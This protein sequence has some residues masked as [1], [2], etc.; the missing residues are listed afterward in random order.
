VFI[1]CPGTIER[2]AHGIWL[3]LCVCGVVGTGSGAE[4]DLAW[5]ANSEP[6]LA[7]YRIHYGTESGSLLETIDVGNVTSAK[8]TGLIPGTTY[9]STVTAYNSVDLESSHSSEISFT[10]ALPPTMIDSDNDGLSD[11]FEATHGN[12]QDLD[13]LSDLDGDGLTAMAEFVHGLDPNAPLTQPISS[14]H[15]AQE[16]AEQYLRVR[17]T[18]DP[19]AL[20]FVDV[21]TERR[22][23]LSDPDG[24]Q[25]GQT[26]QV[27]AGPSPEN[28]A[29][30]EVVEQSLYPVSAQRMELIRFRH[31]V[32]TP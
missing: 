17:Y 19:L 20:I 2:V 18:L 10:V 31:T 15:F 30:L 3:L 22:T 5:D 25:A 4:V 26:T 11:H 1:K 6:D 21:Q 28:P 27:S 12:G 9:Y 14:F 24:W 8:I 7:G 32:L 13:P 23:D 29:L 16:G